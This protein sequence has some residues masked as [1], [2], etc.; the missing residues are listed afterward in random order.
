MTWFETPRERYA[1]LLVWGGAAALI[2]WYF[3]FG[4]RARYDYQWRWH[5]VWQYR[6]FLLWGVGTTLHIFAWSLVASLVLGLFCGVGRTTNVRWVR[7]LST[8]YVE[9]FRNIPL[10]VQMWWA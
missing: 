4:P 3:F 5:L 8:G 2:V 9:I 6:R 7:A 10:L 1:F